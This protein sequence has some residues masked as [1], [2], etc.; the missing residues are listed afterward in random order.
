MCLQFSVDNYLL[1]WAL[2]EYGDNLWSPVKTRLEKQVHSMIMLLWETSSLRKFSLHFITMDSVD[3]CNM[4]III[5]GEYYAQ[6]KC[7]E[8]PKIRSVFLVLNYCSL[9]LWFLSL[10]IQLFTILQVLGI[11]IKLI[12][13][14]GANIL[15]GFRSLHRA[16]PSLYPSGIV[17]RVPEQLNMKAITRTCKLM[18]GCS[19]ALCLATVSMVSA[20]I[21]ATEIKPIQ[22]HDSIVGLSGWASAKR[23]F[24]LH[25]HLFHATWM[26][27][28]FLHPF[29][30]NEPRPSRNSQ[31]LDRSS[32]EN[33]SLGSSRR[34]PCFRTPPHHHYHRRSCS[35]FHP[36]DACLQLPASSRSPI[37]SFPPVYVIKFKSNHVGW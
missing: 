1:R 22:L 12:S 32:Q 4:T 10:N 9:V 6:L 20:G 31:E 25:S 36:T 28:P 37:L 14:V 19:L 21:Y 34:C 13:W 7:P 15:W 8:L 35:R 2:T 5:G 3:I 27:Y 17:H 30:R 16:Y 11:A 23:Y 33:P 18:N 24:H 29:P 26:T